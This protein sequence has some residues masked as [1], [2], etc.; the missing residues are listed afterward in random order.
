MVFQSSLGW[1]NDE[2]YLVGDDPRSETAVYEYIY[3]K[4]LLH[5]TAEV[6]LSAVGS[7]PA[8]LEGKQGEAI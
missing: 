7:S 3:G 2:I 6:V 4:A 8:F 5:S 1:G